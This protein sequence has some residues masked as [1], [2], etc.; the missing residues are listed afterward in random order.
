MWPGCQGGRPSWGAWSRPVTVV[1]RVLPVW[2]ARVGL[3]SLS[4]LGSSQSVRGSCLGF[5]IPWWAVK[6]PETSGACRG[7]R[8]AA[9]R[10]AGLEPLVAR[11]HVPGG[12]QDLARDGGLGGVAAVA[13]GDIEVELVPRVARP[14]GLLG[15]FD[16]GPAQRARAGLRERAGARAVAGLLDARRQTGRADEL[17]GRREARDVTDLA[18]DRQAE[19]APDAGDR[20]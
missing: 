17:L 4:A 6:R 7:R 1:G 20:F 12:D 13:L 16:R 19:Q 8:V 2:R 9:A 3:I 5:S 18:G 11:Q 15:G 10:G 14:P